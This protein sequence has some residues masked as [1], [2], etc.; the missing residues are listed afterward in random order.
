MKK[1]EYKV[2]IF[3]NLF[4]WVLSC[5]SSPSPFSPL[6][7]PV[8]QVNSF[9]ASFNLLLPAPSSS[10]SSS[11]INRTI[12]NPIFTPISQMGWAIW[13]HPF[14]A[15]SPS[16]PDPFPSSSVSWKG[17]LE[18]IK[19]VVN[20]V[21]PG[22]EESGMIFFLRIFSGLSIMTSWFLLPG[23]KVDPQKQS[24]SPMTARSVCFL[25]NARCGLEAE[26]WQPL[27]SLSSQEPTADGN[28]IWG[29]V[30]LGGWIK[31]YIFIPD[32]ALLG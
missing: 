15:F 23:A 25:W 19:R 28:A 3:I 13:L 24:P 1:V 26:P 16:S 21:L 2:I 5:L 31:G 18:I 20:Q 6:N 27:R 8:Y 7:H 29:S 22:R 10:Y 12:S 14:R 4:I 32:A 9:P 17:K 30:K 11:N